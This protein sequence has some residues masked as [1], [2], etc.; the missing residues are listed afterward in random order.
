MPNIHHAI[1]IAASA[2]KVYDSIT[3]P[4]G[5]SAWWTPGSTAK[6][7]INS[8]ARFPF[9]DG[10]FKEMKIMELEQGRYIKWKC[11]KGDTEWV[12]TT[13]SFILESG[14]EKLIL[15]SHPEIRGQVDQLT[16]AGLKTLL[17]FHHDNWKNYTPMF[18]ECNYTW[19]MFLRSL[20]LLCENGSGRP[21]PEQ[22]RVE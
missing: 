7:E 9:G 18:A 6:P 12:D 22:H 11:M 15:D 8:L 17:I 14:D 20:K 4:E 2:E 13:L 3:R 1:L 16:K 21:W 5:L 10:Y 19:A